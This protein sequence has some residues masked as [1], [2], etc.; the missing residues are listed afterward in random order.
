M[1]NI[2]VRVML[3]C[4]IVGFFLAILTG[5]IVLP[6]LKSLKAGQKVLEECPENHHTKSGTPTMGGIIFIIAAAIVCLFITKDQKAMFVIAA[7]VLFGLFGFVDDFIKVVMKRNLGLRAYQKIIGL[8]LIT[9]VIFFL[10][11]TMIGWDTKLLVPFTEFYI[12]LGIWYIPFTT[13][14]I[15][16]A[17]NAVNLTDG[18]D[19]LASSVTLP[20]AAFFAIAGLVMSEK[21]ILIAA[22]ALFGA[23]LGFLK[24]NSHPAEV[25]MGDTG[26][27]AIGGAIV[28]LAIASKLQLFL[29]IVGFIYILEALSVLI[30]ITYFKYSKGKRIL[31]MAPI[32][33]HFEIV[34]WKE[35]KITAV[36]AII[37]T[38][39]VAVALMGFNK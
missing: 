33:H 25:F 35:T 38:V 16:G 17:T 13:F 7:M 39:L 37:S 3:I 23:L 19:G 30:Q 22:A 21:G 32:H 31:K 5:Q 10:Y 8:A 20:V 27:F 4:T 1:L 36:F 26:S 11:Y 12:D 18:L 2:D 15:I 9:A 28:A 24:Y 14:V 34:G 6:L 29:V